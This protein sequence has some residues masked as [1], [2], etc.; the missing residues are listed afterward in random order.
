MR[1]LKLV[2]D[3]I[4]FSILEKI[5]FFRGVVASMTNNPT[6]PNPD[7]PLATATALVDQLEKD[8]IAAQDG[9]KTATATMHESE[10]KAVV[11]F[12]KLADYVDR[13]ADGDEALILSSGFHLSKE[14]SPAKR[15]ELSATQDDLPGVVFL[16][17]QAVQDARAYVWQYCTGDA[18]AAE[19]GWTF[20]GATTKASHEVSGLTSGGKYWF[21]V[22]AVTTEGT[23]AYCAAVYR[24]VQ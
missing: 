10:E 18:P 9:G 22:A 15:V 7:V 23:T 19:N 2:L 4:K 12:R 3:F 21:R 1:K 24:L 8:Y 20:A 16:K 17:R 5:S 11:A 6:Y 14:P 13:V